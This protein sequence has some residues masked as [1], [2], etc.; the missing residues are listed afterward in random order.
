LGLYNYIVRESTPNRKTCYN[1]RIKPRKKEDIL[2]SCRDTNSKE[3][4]D[5]L[6]AKLEIGMG[7]LI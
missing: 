3:V 4:L 7:D 1:I 5:N 6:L 2:K